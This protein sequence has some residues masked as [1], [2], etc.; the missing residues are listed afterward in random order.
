M[1]IIIMT[2]QIIETNLTR[3]NGELIEVRQELVTTE[4]GQ[5]FIVW[6]V[7]GT[8]AKDIRIQQSFDFTFKGYQTHGTAKV[9]RVSF[10]S[11]LEYMV[12]NAN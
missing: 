7:D 1:R 10:K 6:T 4:S 8:D 5:T 2:N 9:K 12:K 3:I 11:V